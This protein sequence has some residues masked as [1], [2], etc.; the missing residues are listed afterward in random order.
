MVPGR[1]FRAVTGMS[2][3]MLGAIAW[4]WNCRKHEPRFFPISE[5][6]RLSLNR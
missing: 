4:G 5:R 2:G 6:D 3:R 1:A